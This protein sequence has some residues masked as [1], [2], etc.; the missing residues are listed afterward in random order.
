MNPCN[1]KFE[2][3]KKMCNMQIISHVWWFI[4]QDGEAHPAYFAHWLHLD[5]LD[6]KPKAV[7]WGL[8]KVV[9]IGRLGGKSDL[10]ELLVQWRGSRFFLVPSPG[11]ER[12]LSSLHN[13]W[14]PRPLLGWHP[15]CH[16]DTAE[17]FPSKK[18]EAWIQKWFIPCHSTPLISWQRFS[19]FECCFY[20][21]LQ[22][23][24]EQLEEPLFHSPLCCLH[25]GQYLAHSSNL[26]KNES[27][28]CRGVEWELDFTWF[29]VKRKAI[30]G[31]VFRQL[32]HFSERKMSF[33]QKSCLPHE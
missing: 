16:Q 22:A 12:S 3:P 32:I 19:A 20:I 2:S 23:S 31:E 8:W 13:R 9:R 25:W 27:F 1:N 5:F 33:S 15:P 17:T 7:I 30:W 28:K 18:W 21:K 24:W 6:R 10:E 4:S 26:G 14:L 29:R 11:P